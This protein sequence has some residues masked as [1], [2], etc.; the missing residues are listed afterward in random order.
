MKKCF[1]ILPAFLIAGVFSTLPAAT[2]AVSFTATPISDAFVATGTNGNLSADNFGAAGSLAVAAPG[3]P[4][5]EFQSVLQFDLSGARSSF[6]AQFG[7]GQW[8]V[9]S[10]TLQ[11]TASPH[12]NSIF[13]NIAAGQ[14]NVSLMR[15]NSWMEGTGT[16]GI[17]TTDGI[18]FNSLQATYINNLTDQALGTFGFNGAS[19]GASLY[20]LG[21]TSG[22]VGDVLGG[23]DLSLRLFAADSQVSYLFSSRSAGPSARPDL[24]INVGVIPEPASLALWALALAVLFLVQWARRMVAGKS[25]PSAVRHSDPNLRVLRK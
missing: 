25:A 20:G 17:P 11:L 10:V 8:A 19:N 1:K 13:N 21:L 24:I 3:L 22:L 23:N 16:G 5:G 2:R 7:A 14:F 12:G 9:Q 18:S 6:D 4:E 15:N